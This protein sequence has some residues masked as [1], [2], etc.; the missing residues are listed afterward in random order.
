M[1][2]AP[3]IWI[4]EILFRFFLITENSVQI[5]LHGIPWSWLEFI[6]HT[7]GV[8]FLLFIGNIFAVSIGASG[9][10][11]SSGHLQQRR[12]SARRRCG[13]SST[14]REWRHRNT[15]NNNS[16]FICND[17]RYKWYNVVVILHHY[18]WTHL[19]SLMWLFAWSD[20]MRTQ[21]T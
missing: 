2:F 9:V 14:A 21:T 18:S 16:K 8:H 10:T 3:A 17:I 19:T 12:R 4:R 6:A 1:W 5:T 20:I 13:C 11:S 15:G 7:V